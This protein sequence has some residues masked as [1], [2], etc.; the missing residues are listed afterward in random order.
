MIFST[1]L[2]KIYE[3]IKKQP[4]DKSVVLLA[5]LEEKLLGNK[6]LAHKF[7][8]LE[9]I[10]ANHKNMGP[11]KAREFVKNLKEAHNSF[12]A[13]NKEIALFYKE[14]KKLFEYFNIDQREVVSGPLDLIINKK[15]NQL[16]ES[17]ILEYVTNDNFIS[18]EEY[19]PILRKNLRESYSRIKIN[20]DYEQFEKR[21][22]IVEGKINAMTGK[23]KELFEAALKVV[24]ETAYKDFDTAVN[25]GYKLN[26][27]ASKML[28]E[29]E[30]IL[31]PSITNSRTPEKSTREFNKEEGVE[32]QA[33]SIPEKFGNIGD[34]NGTL[35]TEN[36]V[37]IDINFTLTLY[38]TSTT[39]G[40]TMHEKEVTLR[41]LK[42]LKGQFANK[43]IYQ[44]GLRLLSPEKFVWIVESLSDV[45]PQKKGSKEN[46]EVL[47]N[48]YYTIPYFFNI[49]LQTTRKASAAGYENEIELM[50]ETFNEMLR[51]AEGIADQMTS[52]LQ[53]ENW[54]STEMGVRATSYGKRDGQD[55]YFTD[56]RQTQG[57][58]NFTNNIFT[59]DV[60][61]SEV[62][63]EYDWDTA[64]NKKGG[65]QKEPSEFQDFGDDDDWDRMA[66]AH[67]KSGGR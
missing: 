39:M 17:I 33:F 20:N 41:K 38:P 47:K 7:N 37:G 18:K 14:E 67:A 28:L 42:G 6:A 15:D 31:D 2:N 10:K 9:A 21:M 25:K 53:V 49:V 13:E 34:I 24:N 3:S 61:D 40:D 29:Y 65:S 59:G 46:N 8:L 50:L 11:K 55:K 19:L 60:E 64:L 12:I 4:R 45:N 63:P 58:D 27:L 5:T 35:P 1:G 51:E 22:S 36:E 57:S 54:K 32:G 23:N 56:K 30:P 16:N 52:D 44:Q 62:D 66:T 43:C 26:L 48:G